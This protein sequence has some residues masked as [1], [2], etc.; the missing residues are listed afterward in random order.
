MIGKMLAEGME[1]LRKIKFNYVDQAAETASSRRITQ[2]YLD[3][4]TI[5]MRVIDSGPASTEMSLFGRTFATP[6]MTAALGG[7]KSICADPMVEAAKGTTAAGS[8][9]WVGVGESAEL[10]AVIETGA[11]AVKVIKP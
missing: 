1:Q 9:T 6:V 8:V 2:E 5:E 7:L 4:L 11:A 3:S 10:Q